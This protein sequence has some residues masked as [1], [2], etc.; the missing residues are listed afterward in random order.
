MSSREGG[1]TDSE[2]HVPEPPDDNFRKREADAGGTNASR[3]STPA[4]GTRG[5]P[6]SYR[7][8]VEGAGVEL[9][10]SHWQDMRWSFLYERGPSIYRSDEDAPRRVADANRRARAG[11]EV[12][13]GRQ[14]PM[15]KAAVWTW[16]VPLYFWFGG[17]ASGSAFVSLACDLAGDHRSAAIA[18]KVSLTAVAPCPVLLVSDLGRPARFLNMLRIF[19]PRS[20]MSMGAWCLFA[21][22]NTAGLAVT[23]DVVGRRRI[24]RGLGAVNAVLGGY[25]GSY[26][27]VLLSSTAVP[28]WA[29]SKRFLGPIFVATATATGAAAVRLV[30]SATGMPAKHP[31]R[32]A[33][34]RIETGAMASELV[35]SGVLERRLGRAAQTLGEGSAKWLFRV[36]KWSTRAGL[37]SRVARGGLAAPAGHAASG[38]FL[39]GALAFRYAWVHAGRASAHNDEI[40][41][42][43]ARGRVTRAEGAVKD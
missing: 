39:V 11:G 31:T 15:M 21:F 20:P 14:G 19:K 28:V 16:E 32:S 42:L 2:P 22:G 23:A 25:L 12:P 17:I 37:A 30:L 26:A 36:A 33:L 6:A 18:R 5:Q 27:G 40:V 34:V 10:D 24:G 38:L 4:L 8:A 41:G 13:T 3:D 35:L 29:R 43:T 7:R 9:H 1:R